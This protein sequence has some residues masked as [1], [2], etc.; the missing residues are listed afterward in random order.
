MPMKDRHK[1]PITILI[2]DDDAAERAL[3]RQALERAHISNGLRF[4]NDG[5]QLLDYLY[6]RGEFS[7]ETGAAPRPGIILLDLDM[8]VMDGRQVLRHIQ[9]DATLLDIP[10]VLL[11]TPAYDANV[12]GIDQLDVCACMAKPVTFSRLVDAMSA[13]GRYWLEIVELP[14]VPSLR[15]ATASSATF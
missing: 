13:L 10:V 14:P 11:T 7:G 12:T 4:V 8:P 6:Q 15:A 1:I 2:C 3:T 5:A 9:S